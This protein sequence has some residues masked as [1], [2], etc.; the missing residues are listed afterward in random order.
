MTYLKLLKA[1][2]EHS[3]QLMGAVKDLPEMQGEGNKRFLLTSIHK[4]NIDINSKYVELINIKEDLK[5][6]VI[7]LRRIPSKKFYEENVISELDY[8]KYHLEVF[9]H[10]VA[11]GS[12][13]LKL[14]VNILFD[15]KIDNR[16]CNMKN[17]KKNLPEEHHQSFIK[18]IE[19]YD[20]TFETI[21][22][23]RNKNS[24]E[25]KF[26][27][28]EFERLALFDN[29]YKNSKKFDL[30]TE[31]LNLIM[32]VGYLEFKIKEL[33]KGKIEWITDAIIAYE[34]YIDKMIENSTYI[35]FKK[36]K[37]WEEEIP[38]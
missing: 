11:T 28:E 29:L 19:A 33:R 34:K 27:D 25:A 20:K 3:G 36:Y 37:S 30:K 35:Y 15:L 23:F 26:Y 21:K 1:F 13:L 2:G 17:L 32:P 6:V 8:V 38:K 22:F 5:K 10:K 24:H 31:S 9:F 18:L 12:D 16:N 4:L 14:L 7:F